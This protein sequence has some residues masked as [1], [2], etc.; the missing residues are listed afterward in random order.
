MTLRV[1]LLTYAFVLRLQHNCV[2]YSTMLT[3]YKPRIAVIATLLNFVRLFRR[4]HEENCKE[5]EL[6]KKKA[7]KEAEAEKSGSPMKRNSKEGESPM[8]RNTT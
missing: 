7:E 3:C 5:A 6:E 2:P 1:P 4:A 8:K